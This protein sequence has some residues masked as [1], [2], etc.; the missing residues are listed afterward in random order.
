[1]V[2]IENV[3]ARIVYE[4]S[5]ADSIH[6]QRFHDE[7]MLVIS[8]TKGIRRYVMLAGLINLPRVDDGVGESHNK[9]TP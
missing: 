6:P 3:T 1:M 9:A 2:S 8:V 5:I 4:T 7:K